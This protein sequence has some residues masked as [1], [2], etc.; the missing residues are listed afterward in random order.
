MHRNNDVVLFIVLVGSFLSML[1][2]FV[3]SALAQPYPSPT[4]AQAAT[5]TAT[6]TRTIVP[7]TATPEP[8]S[9]RAAYLPIVY[10]GS[11]TAS[12]T[13]TPTPLPAGPKLLQLSLPAF[14]G[15]PIFAQPL[16]ADQI[17]LIFTGFTRCEWD[18]TPYSLDCNTF[19]NR[20]NVINAD[21]TR[22]VDITRWIFGDCIAE[23]RPSL[24][25]GTVAGFGLGDFDTCIVLGADGQPPIDAAAQALTSAPDWSALMQPATS[26]LSVIDWPWPPTVLR[27]GDTFEVR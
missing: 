22:G 3:A 11:D 17:L 27:D 20:A 19:A 18:D 21:G 7:S 5:A 26:D 15:A 14:Q 24:N 23:K 4:Q 10:G 12:P 9:Y 16:S 13:P 25:N 1:M 6:A 2:L 8:P